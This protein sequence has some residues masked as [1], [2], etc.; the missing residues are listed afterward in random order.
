MVHPHY[1]LEIDQSQTFAKARGIVFSLEKKWGNQREYE[2]NQR[3]VGLE[4]KRHRKIWLV[5]RANVAWL[6]STK[7][8]HQYLST[9]IQQ[10]SNNFSL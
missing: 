10:N 3:D 7:V 1:K 2:V 5:S 4:I 8:D 6:F 9:K